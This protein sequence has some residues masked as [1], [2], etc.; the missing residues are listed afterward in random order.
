MEE[1]WKDI[2][3]YEGMYQVSSFGRVK[4]IPR[5]R[6]SGKIMDVACNGHYWRIKLSKNGKSRRVM[7]HRIIAEAFIP[8]PENKPQVNHING[9]KKDN[10]IENL[11]WV[12]ISENQ[13]HAIKTGLRPIK[14]KTG[15]KVINTK[16]MRVFESIKEASREKGI[17]RCYLALKL[18]GELKNNTNYMFLS[19]FE[20]K[21]K[22]E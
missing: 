17:D 6:V 20:S 3:G 10:S 9:N 2:K 8:N 14:T 4:S 1:V 16:T 5:Y 13:I 21:I 11:E 18:K 15:T 12:T 22:N 7:L 19:D